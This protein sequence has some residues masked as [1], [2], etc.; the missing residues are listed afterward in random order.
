M[1]T[2]TLS[3]EAEWPQVAGAVIEA[4]SPS[5]GAA[6]GGDPLC[7]RRRAAARCTAL[8]PTRLLWPRDG[9]GADAATLTTDT[10]R[11]VWEGLPHGRHVSVR[12]RGC[13]ALS[14]ADCCCRFAM[15]A[16][17]TTFAGRSR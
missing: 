15:S 12:A 16:R 8:T 7:R 17:G 9:G 5:H 2:S 11:R 10:T 6:P 1:P 14:R 13:L 4:D 3:G